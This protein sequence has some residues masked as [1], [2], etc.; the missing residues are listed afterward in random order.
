[1]TVALCWSGSWTFGKL[2]VMAVPPIELSAIRFA[3]AG[4]LM[5]ALARIA[6][7]SLGLERWRLLILAG[8]FGIFV[9]NALVFFALTISPASDGALIVPTIN[10]VLTVVFATFIGERLTMNKLVG[11]GLA[12]VGA[13][14]VIAAA[15][16]LTFTGQR[17]TADLLY[18]GGAAAWSAYATIGAI[19]TRHGSPL[20][21]TAVACLS[22]AAMLFPLGFLEKGYADVPS[23]PVFAWLDIAYLVVFATIV[24]FVLFYWGVRR[25][26]AGTASM[27]S[28]LVPIFAL[29]QAVL[30]LG[31]QPEPLEVIGGAV[32]LAGV[33]VATWRS[34]PRSA[35]Q[36]TEPA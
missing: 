26:G 15:T 31:E 24:G 18:L 14:L 10:P 36:E 25:F 16:G 29:V 3:I 12:T 20:G 13:I 28:Y 30:I 8:F 4:V 32:I 27:V 2:G 6:K 22:G 5:L 7:Q 33:R 11:L 9:Y 34:A 23:W 19:T 17:L 35:T 1:M 21:V